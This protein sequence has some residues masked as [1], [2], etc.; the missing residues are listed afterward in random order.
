MTKVSNND[1]INKIKLWLENATEPG[2]VSL[3]AASC[4]L[5]LHL[6]NGKVLNFLI[7]QTDLRL[8][9]AT[10]SWQGFNKVDS[11]QPFI[12]ISSNQILQRHD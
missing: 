1:S 12:S 7:S 3:P 9:Y 6:E 10:I 8:T 2:F 5:N 4:K 11:N